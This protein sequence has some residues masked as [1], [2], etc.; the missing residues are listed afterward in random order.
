SGASEEFFYTGTTF[1]GMKQWV[2][3]TL[4][5]YT[6]WNVNGSTGRI[7]KFQK[8]ELESPYSVVASN[9]YVYSSTNNQLL[10]YEKFGN[11]YSIIR[12]ATNHTK[13]LVHPDSSSIEYKTERPGG[14]IAKTTTVTDDSSTVI[15][16]SEVETQVGSGLIL[17][18]TDGLNHQ[19]TYMYGFDIDSDTDEEYA[20]LL[21]KVTQPLSNYTK[22]TY[23]ATQ[24]S[25]VSQKSS[26]NS[27][28]AYTQYDY[29]SDGRVIKT[30]TGTLSETNRGYEDDNL[31]LITDGE[32]RKTYFDYDNDDQLAGVGNGSA[33]TTFEYDSDGRRERTQSPTGIRTGYEYHEPTGKLLKVYNDVAS[34]SLCAT[35]YEYDIDN[36]GDNLTAVIDAE[37]RKTGYGYDDWG[38]LTSE[39]IYSGTNSGNYS[40]AD[41]ITY[42]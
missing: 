32:G 31:R 21:H 27:E 29:D 42:H 18:A 8:R 36:Y 16:K 37:G 25:R 23:D 22:Y 33:T 11:T 10:S 38:R 12:N 14:S 4:L 28:L 13:T 40:V 5:D 2:N 41:S 34:S 7:E 26:G 3:G 9:D 35:T 15:A 1:T 17:F 30:Y 24:V 39:N 20:S 6:T 19:T